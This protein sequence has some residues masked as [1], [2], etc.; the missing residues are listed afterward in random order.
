VGGG[1]TCNSKKMNENVPKAMPFNSSS[2]LDNNSVVTMV[3]APR[4]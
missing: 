2:S 3:Q 1:A 4:T